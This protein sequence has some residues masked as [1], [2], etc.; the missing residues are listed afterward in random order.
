MVP[1]Y[2]IVIGSPPE[3]LNEN[4]V[5]NVERKLNKG[6]FLNFGY[7]LIKIQPWYVRYQ[8]IKF[9]DDVDEQFKKLMTLED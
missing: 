1:R 2:L 9:F 6:E 5:S 7:D 8:L 4:K 3:C